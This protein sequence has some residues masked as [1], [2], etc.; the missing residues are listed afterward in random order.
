MIHQNAPVFALRKAFPVL[1]KEMIIR[2]LKTDSRGIRAGN[3]FL[4]ESPRELVRELL[5]KFFR[6][7]A[8]KFF[9]K[10]QKTLFSRLDSG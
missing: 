3:K 10:L 6:E 7:L 2:N 4:R 5:Q 8:Q 1:G 9:Q